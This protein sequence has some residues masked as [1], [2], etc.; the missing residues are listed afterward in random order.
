MEKWG[1][2]EDGAFPLLWDGVPG[3]GPVFPTHWDLLWN[4]VLMV[5]ACFHLLKLS[6]LPCGIVTG[7]GVL[8][9]LAH[10]CCVP[11]RELRARG[12]P[13]PGLA[14]NGPGPFGEMNAS[15]PTEPATWAVTVL[16]LPGSSSGAAPLGR[17][18]CWQH[19][20]R[21]PSDWIPFSSC[22]FSV[23]RGTELWLIWMSKVSDM[24][25]RMC[26]EVWIFNSD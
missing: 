3:E 20:G 18:F 13:A 24:V 7:C 6:A 1:A 4:D 16:I 15:L 8:N 2:L 11:G 17:V 22:A 25:M 10:D 14:S 23:G 9:G 26:W 5:N 12:V 19:S 21:L